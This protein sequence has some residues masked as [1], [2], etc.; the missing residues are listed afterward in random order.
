VEGLHLDTRNWEAAVKY[1]ALLAL[2]VSAALAA[3]DP[4]L[5]GVKDEQM[6]RILVLARGR[7]LP[8][9]ALAAARARTPVA[10][11]NEAI[12]AR[13]LEAEANLA[14]IRG[15]LDERAK[16]QPGS[17]AEL[18]TLWL[19]NGL[20]AVTTGRLARAIAARPDVADVM[21]DRP[22][23]WLSSISR[24]APSSRLPSVWGIDRIHAA[25]VWATGN[26]GQD[27]TIGL[28]DTGADGT[29]P[30]LAGRIKK[31]RNFLKWGAPVEAPFDDRGHGTHCAG[32]IAGGKNHGVSIGVAPRA[33]LL[34]AK[35]L[36]KNGAGGNSGLIKALQWMADPDGNP[37]TRDQPTAVSCSWGSYTWLPL[38]GRVFWSAVN[39]LRTADVVP[40][41]ASGNDG[42]GKLSVPGSYPHSLAVGATDDRDKVAEFTSY[43]TTSWSG[44]SVIKPDISAPGDFIYSCVPGNKYEYMSG[45]SMATPIVAGA[46]AL[47]KAKKPSLNGA[48]IQQLLYRS[49]KD[50]GTPGTDSVF[51]HGLLDVERA[52]AL[53]QTAS[54]E[55][56][57]AASGLEPWGERGAAQKRP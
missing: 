21:V 4:E 11:G 29:H 37:G 3:T 22:R 12:F 53:T 43:G 14:G 8:P 38:F 10:P 30:D 2:S 33:Q 31:F 25:A 32:L 39:G 49:A 45:T 46:I 24:H 20:S 35:A 48:Q 28:V 18:E 15:A 13:R 47:I 26:E 27:V 50:L 51:G 55:A 23:V 17:V 41:F 57:P 34:V 16:G 56:I 54:A 42:P 40:L 36:D 52:V 9:G 19:V 44:V 1:L 5:A 7:G 6:V